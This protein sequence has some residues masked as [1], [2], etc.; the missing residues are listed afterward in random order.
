MQRH[1][2]RVA[3]NIIFR[4]ILALIFGL[5]VGK[6]LPILIQSIFYAI[7]LTLKESLI[8]LLPFI[9]FS[10]IFSCLLSF[11]SDVFKFIIILILCICLSNF[12]ST[13]IGYNVS[14]ITL[15]NLEN[16]SNINNTTKESL[17]PYWDFK[18]PVLISNNV[19]LF[20]GLIGGLIFSKFRKPRI[21][22]LS[23]KLRDYVTLFLNKAFIPVLPIFALGFIIKLES[24]GILSQILSSYLPLVL[25]IIITQFVYIAI[26][27]FI[28]SGFNIKQFIYF[29]KNVMP[30]GIMGFS[31]MSS[32]AALPLTIQ[33]AEKNTKKVDLSRTIAPATVNIH[34]IGDS[35]AIP[36][37]ALVIMSTFGSGFPDFSTFL[38]FSFYF[39]LAKFAVAAV[40]GGGILVMITILETHL[41]FTPEMGGLITALYI[42]LDP[43]ITSA[44]VLGNGAFTIITSK[45]LSGKTV[46]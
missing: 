46:N 17:N 3:N 35:I 9:I 39:V 34:L 36:M 28:G 11:K 2:S 22:F 40:P 12:I 21:D 44:N 20:S 41:G 27:Y 15:S 8:F 6:Y 18:I 38:V 16:F 42:L 43:I 19:A 32:M 33:A 45:I 24:D 29:I 30:A 26:L 13:I 31:S 25:A 4:L 37:I 10:C 7:S 23:N 1:I 14:H 5:F